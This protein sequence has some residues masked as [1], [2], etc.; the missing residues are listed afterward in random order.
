MRL[1]TEKAKQTRVPIKTVLPEPERIYSKDF[2]FLDEP[3]I[4][5][6]LKKDASKTNSISKKSDEEIEESKEEKAEKA[7]PDSSTPTNDTLSLSTE[8]IQQSDSKN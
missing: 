6:Q 2:H 1:A 8:Q 7:N 4:N 3:L 5:R